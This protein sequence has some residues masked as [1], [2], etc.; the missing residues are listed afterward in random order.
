[1][2]V[3]PGI[4][5]YPGGPLALLTVKAYFANGLRRVAAGRVVGETRSS[6]LCHL[7]YYGDGAPLLMNDDS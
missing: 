2:E 5:H 6:D 7:S 1:M 3:G 4:L